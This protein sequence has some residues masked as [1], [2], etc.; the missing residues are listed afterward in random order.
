MWLKKQQCVNVT[1]RG[2]SHVSLQTCRRVSNCLLALTRLHVSWRGIDE[3]A[4]ANVA[5]QPVWHW[6]GF[7]WCDGTLTCQHMAASLQWDMRQ[8]SF[9]RSSASRVL[10]FFCTSLMM[11]NAV[12]RLDD[13]AEISP[14]SLELELRNVL[15]RQQSYSVDKLWHKH[16][17]SIY[18]ISP[19][20]L[21][22]TRASIIWFS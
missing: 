1:S 8:T 3:A 17:L 4:S 11:R 14:G 2:L 10:N 9:S 15:H 22:V 5:C 18:T 20:F 16:V 12:F 6:H 19:T 13:G 7:T 21:A